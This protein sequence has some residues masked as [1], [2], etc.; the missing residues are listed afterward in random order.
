MLWQLYRERSSTVSNKIPSANDLRDIAQ[1]LT[2]LKERKDISP[3][4]IKA[5]K[6]TPATKATAVTREVEYY[7]NIIRGVS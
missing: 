2:R 3:A 4:S 7:M 6:D 5:K 1:H